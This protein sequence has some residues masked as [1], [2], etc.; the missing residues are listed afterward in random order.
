MFAI[1]ISREMR[2]KNWFSRLLFCR[3]SNSIR[4]VG[5]FIVCFFFWFCWGPCDSSRFRNVYVSL[6][7][8]SM[9]ALAF[10]YNWCVEEWRFFICTFSV[11]F[12][13]QWL[14]VFVWLVTLSYF[15]HQSRAVEK[16]WAL[17]SNI[18]DIHISGQQKVPS[19]FCA[20]VGVTYH[21]VNK[22]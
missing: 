21:S 10:A 7:N 2:G 20:I 9:G 17:H 13:R 5:A 14:F 11:F 6:I 15:I 22:K 3:C 18:I 1:S 16:C 8:T 12:L 4:L 19:T